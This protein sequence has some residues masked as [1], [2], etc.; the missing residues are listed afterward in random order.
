MPSAAQF[1]PGNTQRSSAGS[2]GIA[3]GRAGN[4][5]PGD[6]AAIHVAEFR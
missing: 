6:F 4:D 2:H 1:Q 5:D 3:P